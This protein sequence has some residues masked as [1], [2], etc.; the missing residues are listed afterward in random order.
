M[1]KER[2]SR[3]K[4]SRSKPRSEKQN[5]VTWGHLMK[6]ETEREGDETGQ[7][8]GT[9]NHGSLEGQE[10]HWEALKVGQEMEPV[11]AQPGGGRRR[12]GDGKWTDR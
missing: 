11:G 6:W 4:S 9:P 8:A 3:Q 1:R 7:V 5:G 10:S 2:W 12:L